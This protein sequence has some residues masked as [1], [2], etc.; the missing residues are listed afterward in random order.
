MTNHFPNPA[1][2]YLQP[3]ITF[4]I[5]EFPVFH[6]RGG[7]S[8]GIV[9][10][11]RHLPND[12]ALRDE[13]IRQLMGVPLQGET[14]GNRQA[15]GLGRG[16]PTSNKVFIV[17]IDPTR[18]LITSTLAQLAA[19]KSAIDWSVNCGNMSA[20]LPLYALDTGLIAIDSA[21]GKPTFKVD[22]FNTNTNSQLS[23]NMQLNGHH[24]LIADTE[25]PGID[26]AFP[27]V[28]LYLHAP[29][30]AKTGAL[31]PTG[32]V[33]DHING[34]DVSCVDVAVPMVIVAAVDLGKTGNES[35]AELDADTTF[36]TRLRELWVAAGLKMGLKQRSGELM[37][38][39][40]LA[41]SETIPKICMVSA[42]QHGGHISTRYFTPQSA[43]SSLAVSGGCCLASACL[44]P[45][46]V[47]QRIASATPA[48]ST[49]AVDTHTLYDIAIENPAGILDTR[50]EAN[51]TAGQVHILQAAY[52]RN[53]QILLRGTFPIYRASAALGDF[54]KANSPLT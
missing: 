51:T 40:Q 23:A 30:G 38:T 45:G 3:K 24:N 50:I 16:T 21:S 22:I 33:V 46:S 32:Q 5:P 28:D 7:T 8:S 48:V 15:N 36:K 19:D 43:H 11:Q 34:V 18:R 12:E 47:A 39:V 54:F 42:P 6:M 53:A 10:W 2:A 27:G 20:A 25:I 44:I 14:K 9:I 26:G 4:G 31:L 35:P 1:L 41:A 29:V 13:L 37:S 17:D 52:R 49:H